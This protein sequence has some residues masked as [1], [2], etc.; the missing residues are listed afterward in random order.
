MGVHICMF[1]NNRGLN[2]PRVTREAEVA[3]QAG[4]R[5]TVVAVQL[6]G[7]NAPVCKVQRGVTFLRPKYRPSKAVKLLKGL[8]RAARPGCTSA[9]PDREPRKR[10]SAHEHKLSLFRRIQ[11]ALWGWRY[12]SLRILQR[13]HAG[14]GV[15]ADIYH[16]H[17]CDTLGVAWICSRLR[18]R[19]L[20]YD[21]HELWVDWKVMGG[22]SKTTAAAWRILEKNLVSECSLCITVSDGVGTILRQRYHP[23]RLVVVRNCPRMPKQ[24]KL[25]E[26]EQARAACGI[27]PE[28][29]VVVYQGG[30]FA[31]RG[32]ETLI[33]AAAEIP[34]IRVLLI[35]RRNDYCAQLQ[36]LARTY[37]SDNVCF[38][39]DRTESERNLIMAAA[40]LGVV[41]T[42]DLSLSYRHSLSNK[43]FEYFCNG[44]PV[45]GS[46]LPEHRRLNSATKACI[47]TDPDNSK[48]VAEKIKGFFLR[49][50]AATREMGRRARSA[51][52]TEYNME[53][54]M[55]PVLDFY[56]ACGSQ[57]GTRFHARRG[58]N[59]SNGGLCE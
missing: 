59:W 34:G 25:I 50:P 39:G 5:V 41:L 19:P 42:Q 23:R 53:K 45:L 51:V 40:D 15:D 54:Q 29:K 55:R 1:V 57:E 18:G 38:L 31:F 21:S 32:L 58:A 9:A 24:S 28:A 17:D 47:L 26:K 2:D 49:D 14:L 48:D 33:K 13:L 52:L 3:V 44:T 20:V 46:D 4:F 37:H 43:I 36:D 35:G 16:A 6:P 30:I 8:F 10:P 12:N 7:E 56:A 11:N 22:A 27:P